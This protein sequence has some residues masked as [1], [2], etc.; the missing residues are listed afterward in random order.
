M[1]FKKLPEVNVVCPFSNK[2][3][4]I[5]PFLYLVHTHFDGFEDFRESISVIIEDF[6]MYKSEMHELATISY[7]SHISDL[8]VLRRA[9]GSVIKGKASVW[10]E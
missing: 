5:A 9:I 1:S 10:E 3:V 6:G 8:A 4:N 7:C 2:E